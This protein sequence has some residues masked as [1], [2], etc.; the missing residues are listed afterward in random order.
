[1]AAEIFAR[2]SS[3]W[4]ITSITPVSGLTSR[5]LRAAILDIISFRNA[6][7]LRHL[8][9][10]DSLI[11]CRTSSF[12]FT[13]LETSII[14]ARYAGSVDHRLRKDSEIFW[15]VSSEW[16]KPRRTWTGLTGRGLSSPAANFCFNISLILRFVS[17]VGRYPPF[18]VRRARFSASFAARSARLRSS[19]SSSVIP[20][21]SN[22]CKNRSL[23]FARTPAAIR[24]LTS[25]VRF[26]PL[27]QGTFPLLAAEILARD[28]CVW[29]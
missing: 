25:S 11:F 22:F 26:I 4:W 24:A 28:A 9:R 3:S 7:S 23:F 15:R 18:S 21:S 27:F 29:E 16:V 2:C 8:L 12:V 17:S 1:M 14:L 13:R 5:R 20:I 6:S 19:Y 10:N